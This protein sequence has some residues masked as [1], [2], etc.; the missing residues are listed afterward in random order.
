[1]NAAVLKAVEMP[2]V[3]K[4]LVGQ[5]YDVVGGTPLEF[6]NLIQSDLAKYARVIREAKIRIN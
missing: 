5:G 6:S 1:M 2:D 4:R 3:Q